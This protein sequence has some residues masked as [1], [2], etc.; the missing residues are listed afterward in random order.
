MSVFKCGLLVYFII[1]LLIMLAGPCGSDQLWGRQCHM[2][3]SRLGPHTALRAE[4]SATPLVCPPSFAL[5]ID[6][7]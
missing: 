4:A 1:V 2:D 5:Y 7:I 6:I 3:L